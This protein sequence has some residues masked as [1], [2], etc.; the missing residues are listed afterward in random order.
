MKRHDMHPSC[1][2]SVLVTEHHTSLALST[3]S[4]PSSKDELDQHC[5]QRYT[6]ACVRY[7]QIGFMLLHVQAPSWV[8]L[9]IHTCHNSWGQRCSLWSIGKKRS[10]LK[11]AAR[12]EWRPV[13]SRYPNT[14][15]HQQLLGHDNSGRRRVVSWSADID[16]IC[17]NPSDQALEGWGSW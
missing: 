1:P 6:A 11:R 10:R 15:K 8:H 2:D 4:R 13:T 5:R 9:S 7:H 12:T 14:I 17:N 16:D 3:L